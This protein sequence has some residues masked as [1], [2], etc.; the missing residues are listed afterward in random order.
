MECEKEKKEKLKV[1]EF[2][3]KGKKQSITKCKLL[4]IFQLFSNAFSI[5]FFEICNEKLKKLIES[6]IEK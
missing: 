1:K 5:R 4:S 2:S 6:L 3:G